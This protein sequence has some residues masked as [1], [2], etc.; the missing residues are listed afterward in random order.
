MPFSEGTPSVSLS[1]PTF[2]AL[3]VIK[4]HIRIMCLLVPAQFSNVLLKN[5]RSCL[6]YSTVE[7]F[8]I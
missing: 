6:F 8:T 3:T 1:S 4:T 7:I 2:G 5:I